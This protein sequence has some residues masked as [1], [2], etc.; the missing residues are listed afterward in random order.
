[1]AGRP[2]KS[3]LE[4][5][6]ARLKLAPRSAPYWVVIG[7]GQ[8]IGYRKGIKDGYWVARLSPPGLIQ[9]LPAGS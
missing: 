3:G 6:T 8:Q 1:M 2:K 9:L 5:K 7:E 4:S